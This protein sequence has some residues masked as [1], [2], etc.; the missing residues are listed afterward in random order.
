MLSN[1][2][3]NAS[4]IVKSGM[5]CLRKRNISAVEVKYA[6][7]LVG[8]ATLFFSLRIKLSGAID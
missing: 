8:G 1:R 3:V 7:D 2:F 5:A 4:L 6:C